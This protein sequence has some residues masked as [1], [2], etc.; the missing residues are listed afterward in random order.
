M[1]DVYAPFL[2]VARGH[3]Q[4]IKVPDGMIKTGMITKEKAEIIALEELK[5]KIY[6]D[7]DAA[8]SFFIKY[9]G[10][11]KELG[12]IQCQICPCTFYRLDENKKLNIIVAC[13][14]LAFWANLLLAIFIS[15]LFG[16]MKQ[17]P[18]PPR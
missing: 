6:G 8:L 4:Y 1:Y 5:K 16:F 15:G 10:I 17:P 2:N 11:L 12:I 9:K 7:L 14:D 18:W 3:T 13:H